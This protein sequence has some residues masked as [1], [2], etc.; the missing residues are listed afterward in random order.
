LKL[1]SFKILFIVALCPIGEWDIRKAA[2][3]GKLKTLNRYWDKKMD[4]IDIRIRME[5]KLKRNVS[6]GVLLGDFSGVNAVQQVN[7]LG[8][9]I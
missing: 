1:K 9:L 3:S 7:F 2:V 6:Q 8:K 5:Q 4:E